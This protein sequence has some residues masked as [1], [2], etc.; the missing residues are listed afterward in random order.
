MNTLAFNFINLDYLETMTEGDTD[1]L[2]T[3]LDMIVGELQNEIP[4]MS[5]HF[6]AQDW[7]GLRQVSHKFKSTLGFVGNELMTEVNREIEEI[8]RTSG[9]F[10]KVPALLQILAEL[11]PDVVQELQTAMHSL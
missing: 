3:M 8:A 10:D 1:M 6:E 5:A 9:Q 2:R 7:E 11:Q 4:K